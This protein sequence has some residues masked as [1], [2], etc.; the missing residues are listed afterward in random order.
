MRALG[1]TCWSVES[2]ST[3]LTEKGHKFSIWPKH[4]KQFV[5]VVTV[6]EALIAAKA[7]PD[8]MFLVLDVPTHFNGVGLKFVGAKHVKFGTYI[9]TSWTLP[10][11]DKFPVFK[12]DKRRMLAKVMIATIKRGKKAA[13]K[14][15]TVTKKVENGKTKG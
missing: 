4:D 14:K 3:L 2:V 10:T 8:K 11:A 9:R 1:I 5:L 13:T 15:T 7:H 6:E 12:F